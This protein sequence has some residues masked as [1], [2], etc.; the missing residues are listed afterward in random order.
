MDVCDLT[1]CAWFVGRGPR[2]TWITPGK[3]VLAAAPEEAPPD[4]RA[5]RGH[6]ASDRRRRR[7]A[8]APPL[9]EPLR[10]RRLSPPASSGEETSSPARVCP[11]HGPSDSARWTRHWDRSE[12]DRALGP[13]VRLLEV[14]EDGGRWSLRVTTG[15]DTRLLSW[16]DAHARLATVLGWDALPS[17]ADRVEPDGDGFRAEGRGRGHRVGLCLAALAG[18]D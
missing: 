10:R 17:P 18:L 15:G 11:R 9:D 5:L 7:G 3:A 13:A 6:V 1:H 8:R 2:V 14:T 4:A 16:D 12:V